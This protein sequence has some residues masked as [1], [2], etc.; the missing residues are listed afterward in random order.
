MEIERDLL[1]SPPVEVLVI[2]GCGR[3][4]FKK[5]TVNLSQVFAGQNVGVKEIAPE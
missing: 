2:D 4:C 1:V 3:I 5:R